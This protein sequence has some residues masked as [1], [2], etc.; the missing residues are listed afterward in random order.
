M[1]AEAQPAAEHVSQE[2][3]DRR[4]RTNFSPITK[5]VVLHSL[6]YFN[7]NFRYFF[8]RKT[9]FLKYSRGFIAM[10]GDFDT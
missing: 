8:A 3:M 6:D 2:R 1:A 7:V 9:M 4:K 10:P 5:L